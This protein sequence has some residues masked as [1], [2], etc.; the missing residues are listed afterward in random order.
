MVNAGGEADRVGTKASRPYR[1]AEGCGCGGVWSKL[2][3]GLGFKMG[4]IWGA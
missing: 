4:S 3:Q 2:Y 1:A